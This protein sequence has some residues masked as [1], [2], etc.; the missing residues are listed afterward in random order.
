MTSPLG[1]AG[2]SIVSQP[3]TVLGAS[4]VAV[5]CPADTT[6][7]ILATINIPAGAMGLNGILRIEWIISHT[8][9]A[10][11]KT[12]RTR[13]GGIGGTV[14]ASFVNTTTGGHRD[15]RQI[16]N[17]GAANSQVC[18]SLG[19]TPFPGA[20]TNP[21]TTGAIDTSVAQTLVITGQKAT[22]GE[23]LTLEDYL[24]ELIIP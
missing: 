13:L 10:N 19:N 17:R 8:N 2:L 5:S 18:W 21:T 22:A 3:V 6:E 16:A 4:A 24:V 23:T 14:F 9:S 12:L 1:S 11:N 7:D 20:V 15:N